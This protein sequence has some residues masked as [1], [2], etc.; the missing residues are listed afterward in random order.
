M[1]DDLNLHF[2]LCRDFFTFSYCLDVSD[3]LSSND[4]QSKVDLPNGRKAINYEIEVE[5]CTCITYYMNIKGY[6]C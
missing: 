4:K 2:I 3:A 5:L 1:L 6:L